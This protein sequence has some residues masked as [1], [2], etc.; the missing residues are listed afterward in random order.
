MIGFVLA[1]LPR[2][3]L[4]L[5]LSAGIGLV[6]YRR[7]SLSGS[8]AAGAM[9][10]GTSVFG[11]GGWVWGGA[12]VAFFVS[13][14]WLSHRGAKRKLA[15]SERFAKGSRRDFAQTLA[16]GGLAALIAL[17]AGYVGHAAP[18]F[19]VLALAFYGALAAATA[20]TWATELGVL[21][22]QSPR[23]ISTGR[24]VPAGTSGGVTLVGLGAAIAGAA[25][26]GLTVFVLV[27]GAS[28][29]TLGAWLLRDWVIVP[30]AAISGLGGALFDSLLG[31][32]VQAVYVCTVCGTETE[33]TIH[34]CGRATRLLRG[35]RWLDNDWVN[36]LASMAGAAVAAGLAVLIY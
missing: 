24:L 8:G 3:I 36:F 28:L 27:Q 11:F 1:I 6:A 15:L 22:K 13:S 35:W 30:V 20:D 17:A 19:P 16:N 4:G 26:I 34:R 12:L 23:L 21:A 29:F 5:V 18:L 33:Q 10:I 32:T 7:G 14:S 2:L 25:F 31:A 9:L